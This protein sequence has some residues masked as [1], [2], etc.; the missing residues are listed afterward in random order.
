MKLVTYSN[1]DKELRFGVI[2]DN[3]VYDSSEVITAYEEEKK[4]ASSNMPS[5]I[6]AFLSLGDNALELLDTASKYFH[7]GS[8]DKGPNGNNLALPLET[9]TLAAP[10]PRPGKIIGIARNYPDMSEFEK[11]PIAKYPYMFAKPVSSI[12]G[13]E[14]PI[15]CPRR[16]NNAVSEVELGFV[17]GKRGRYIPADRAYEY[18]VGY[19]VFNDAGMFGW[20]DDPEE[21]EPPR[22]DWLYG[23]WFDTFSC[24]GPA[25]VTKDEITDPLNLD[26]RTRLNGKEMSEGNTSRMH[27]KIPE[28]VEYIS[29]F[30]TMEPGDVVATG[31]VTAD[32]LKPGDV[33]E[34]I[35]DNVGILRNPVEVEP[36]DVCV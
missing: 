26:F 12:N 33:M 22:M 31:T 35:I 36:D 29:S 21:G 5:E 27:F 8:R 18:I 15:Y 13:H 7:E 24:M 28:L 30:M 25:I 23:K 32:E 34:S 6:I 20:M 3:S 19:T 4:A 10:V 17:I 14:Q 16:F 9:V 2:L 11:A 1:S